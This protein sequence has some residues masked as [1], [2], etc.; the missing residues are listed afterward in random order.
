M[1]FSALVINRIM[2]T[3]TE[4]EEVG[5]RGWFWKEYE[6]YLRLNCWWNLPSPHQEN[7]S[8]IGSG[9]LERMGSGLEGQIQNSPT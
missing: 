6:F 8:Y 5:R 2:V 9:K 1:R 7:S 3:L 4:E